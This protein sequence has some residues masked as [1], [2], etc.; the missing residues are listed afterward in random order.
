MENQK[1]VE[2]YIILILRSFSI[3]KK[4][5]IPCDTSNEI[6]RLTNPIKTNNKSSAP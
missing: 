5:A 1:E 3:V 2:A 6:V 4:R